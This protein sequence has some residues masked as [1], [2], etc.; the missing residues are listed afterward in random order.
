M[1][2]LSLSRGPRTLLGYSGI[3]PPR[4]SGPSHQRIA[5]QQTM[6]AWVAVP[7]N[8]IPQAVRIVNP[9]AKIYTLTRCSPS[10]SL[11]IQSNHLPAT[12]IPLCLIGSRYSRNSP[13]HPIPP[14]LD[15]FQTTSKKA[16]F[17]SIFAKIPE[18]SSITTAPPSFV[19]YIKNQFDIHLMYISIVLCYHMPKMK[20]TP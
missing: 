19:L 20:L 16:V 8:T 12:G 6:H 11:S 7:S 1:D 17:L 3:V 14:V 10:G 18:K 5:I 4:P 2:P 15:F 9:I 13:R